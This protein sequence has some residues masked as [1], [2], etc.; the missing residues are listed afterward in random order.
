MEKCSQ[1]AEDLTVLSLELTSIFDMFKQLMHYPNRVL[2]GFRT[3]RGTLIFDDLGRGLDIFRSYPTIFYFGAVTFRR[4]FP[5][6]SRMS[7]ARVRVLGQR[8]RNTVK[9][10]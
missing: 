9:P 3:L 5:Q 7:L 2:L 1:R 8:Y 10:V 6:K 4:K